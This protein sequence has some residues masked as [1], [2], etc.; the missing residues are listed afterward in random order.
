ME[1][2]NRKQKNLPFCVEKDPLGKIG[3]LTFIEISRCFLNII[4]LLHGLLFCHYDQLK[5]KKH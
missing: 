5:L 4:V 1:K 3:L 2:K